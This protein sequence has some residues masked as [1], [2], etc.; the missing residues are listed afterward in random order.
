LFLGAWTLLYFVAFCYLTSTW[1]KRI[2][3]KSELD[4]GADNARAAIAFS[5]FS[6]GSWVRLQLLIP[7]T[8]DTDY[9]NLKQ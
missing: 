3:P 6:I 2:A 7:A 8:R 4:Y 9:C 5:F 1:A